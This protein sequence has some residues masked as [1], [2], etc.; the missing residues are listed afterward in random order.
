MVQALDY[1]PYVLEDL[2]SGHVGW[3]LRSDLA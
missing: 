3:D 2:G 1:L